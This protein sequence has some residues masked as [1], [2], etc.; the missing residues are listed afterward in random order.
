MVAKKKYPDTEEGRAQKKAAV[1]EQ[2]KKSAARIRKEKKE[3]VNMSKEDTPAPQ[4]QAK[5]TAKETH[6]MPDGTEMAGA[7][8]GVSVSETSETRD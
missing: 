3:K 7:T 1:K 6:T 5:Q 4:Q 2:K 8:H